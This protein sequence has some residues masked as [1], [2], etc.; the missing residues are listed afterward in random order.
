MSYVTFVPILYHIY[1]LNILRTTIYF[2]GQLSNSI[3][4]SPNYDLPHEMKVTN[5]FLP[6]FIV[7]YLFTHKPMILIS[8]LVLIGLLLAK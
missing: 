4:F 5:L 8:L 2:R 7:P 1:S 3:R 6:E